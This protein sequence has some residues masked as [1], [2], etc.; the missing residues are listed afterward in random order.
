MVVVVVVVVVT[1]AWDII[2]NAL[3]TKWCVTVQGPVFSNLVSVESRVLISEWWWIPPAISPFVYVT[4]T[5]SPVDGQNPAH[6]PS[7]WVE[8]IR[9]NTCFIKPRMEQTCAG[10]F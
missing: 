10:T 3:E 1:C 8:K 4:F 6:F 5:L 9:H 7:H 2:Y